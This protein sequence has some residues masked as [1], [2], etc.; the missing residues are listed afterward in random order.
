ML[1]VPK[2]VITSSEQSLSMLSYGQFTGT[3]RLSTA[4][5]LQNN[6][7]CCQQHNF[8]PD[9]VVRIAGVFLSQQAAASVNQT[10]RRGTELTQSGAILHC[11]VAE[12]AYLFVQQKFTT[13]LSTSTTF[14]NNWL[15]RRK[16]TIISIHKSLSMYQAGRLAADKLFIPR[17][18]RNV[19]HYAV[20]NLH[21]VLHRFWT[22]TCSV[23]NME[24][25]L[26][27]FLFN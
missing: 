4:Q 23:C 18:H 8:L 24:E 20:G 9:D 13:P 3:T 17:L 25:R 15:R 2:W 10:R 26:C 14:F 22:D 21:G 19:F 12:V 1:N 11:S 27:F 16:K 6:A 7:W 5:R